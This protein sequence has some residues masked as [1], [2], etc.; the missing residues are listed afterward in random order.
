MATTT[1]DTQLESEATT[2]RWSIAV[3]SGLLAG[4]LMGLVLQFGMGAMA[5]VGALV[6]QPTVAAGWVVHLVISVVFALV[7]A[8]LLGQPLVGKYGTSTART[9]ALGGL[10]GVALWLV[11]AATVMP[12][13][14][15]AMGMTGVPA[16]P[17]LDLLS[18]AGHVLYGVVL[19]GTYSVVTQRS[20]K[21]TA[22][23]TS[24]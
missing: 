11:A 5:M 4:V 17:N 6:G 22:P 19:G 15:A 2:R 20:M 14:L 10:Y 18:L 8:A 13:W 23:E 7:F 9:A 1:T 12:L 21:R 3:A 16:V 24:A